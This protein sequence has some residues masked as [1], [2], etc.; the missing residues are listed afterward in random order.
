M[1]H[2]VRLVVSALAVYGLLFAVSSQATDVSK[3]P[4]KGNLLVKPNVI[5]GM[6][7]SGSMDTEVMLYTNDG[8]F[9]WDFNARSGWGIDAN[10]PSSALRDK[11]ALWFNVDGNAVPR[12]RKMVYL[13][14]NGS[15]TGNRKMLDAEYDHFAVMPT[16]QF[17]FLRSSSY[18]SI[19]YDPMVTYDPW[20]PAHLSTGPVTP[21]NADATAARSHPM[22]GSTTMNLTT[23]VTRPATGVAPAANTVF[24]ALPGMRVPAGASKLVCNAT[25]GGCAANWVDVAA[26]EDASTTGVTRVAMNYYPATY[27]VKESCTVPSTVS[28]ATDSC[29]TAPDGATLKRYEIKSGNTFPSGRS[30]ADEMQNFANWFQY[31]RKR[32]LML[33]AA[34]GETMETLS[35]MRVGVVAF[36]AR[37]NVTMYDTDATSTAAN[38]RR[39]AG[40]F[41]EVNRS[42][43]TPTRETLNYIGKQFARTG[44]VQYACQRNSA[45]IVT[46]G[47]ANA[48]TLNVGNNADNIPAYDAGRSATSFGATGAPYQDIYASSLADIATRYYVNRL[49]GNAFEAGA[50]SPT[51]RDPNTDQHINTY[52]LTMGARGTIFL[53]DKSEPP[54]STTAWP[55]PTAMRSPT[56][57][58]DLWHATI[59][60]RGR[61]YLATTPQETA[62]KI[63]EGLL[64]I[65]NQVGSQS[66][67]AVSSVNLRRG[68]SKAYLGTYNPQGWGGDVT[69]NQIDKGTGVVAK[70]ALWSAAARLAA[71]DWT[72]RVI[73]TYNGSAAVDF[74]A[75]NVGSVINPTGAWGDNSAL[76]DY[77]RGKRT[78]EGTTYRKRTSLIGAIIN[79]RPAV[80]AEDNVIYAASSSGMVH[81]I[82]AT[83][84]E[85][86]WSYVPRSVLPSIGETSDRAWTF[87][88][89]LDGSPT[90]ARIGTKKLLVGGRGAA[91]SGY[92]A[93]DVTT[94][95]AM[96]SPGAFSGKVWEFESSSTA[97]LGLSMGRPVVVDT[98]DYG[99]VVLVT[100]GYNS[101]ANDGKSRLFVLDAATGTVRDTL[102]ADSGF[103]TG[104]PGL[105][106]VSAMSEGTGKVIYVYGGDERGNLWRFNLDDQ[107]V[108]RIATLKDTAGATQ[109]V[110][111]APE[112]ALIEGQRVVLVGTGRLLGLSDFG[113]SQVQS[114]YAIKDAASP[115]SNVRTELVARVLGAESEKNLRS[116]SGDEF[117]WVTNRGWYFDLPS[118]QQANTDP[119]V[120]FGAVA[121][122]T[123]SASISN[124][125]TSSYLYVV[126]LLTG[127]N[128][129]NSEY[130]AI[131][132]NDFLGSSVVILTTDGSQPDIKTVGNITTSNNE[133]VT[134]KLDLNPGVVPRKNSWRQVRRE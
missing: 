36:N 125:K 122:T 65:L 121:F 38:G 80:S 49:G 72:Q 23:N 20:A 96:T 120:A 105:A 70:T 3:R 39:V 91:G 48:S 90:L 67:V 100:S 58:D 15:G 42:G 133:V 118:G 29:T 82:D 11:T 46:D 74:T 115:V 97:P 45:F 52:G 44:I 19:Y 56:S 104:D 27:W 61:M 53:G 30:Y 31:F 22:Y 114:F 69:A 2:S 113:S 62:L 128:V 106:Q 83:N 1:K 57:V 4:I 111:T 101:P 9:W 24:T 73:V 66:S 26:D 55:A 63:Q 50:V 64:D 81:A 93:I 79:A 32:Q 21:G 60:G 123:N 43:G 13:F 33:A 78:G 127:L 34:M 110:T 109:P 98:A 84:G 126:D 87:E 51:E 112:L 102:V 35:G 37:S 68:D 75:G 14:P 12:W 132:V 47:F 54:T 119:T 18:N 77:L 107:T 117:N 40:V 71:R 6:D 108:T 134:E 86:L 7:D 28:V 41:Y 99:P 16:T 95:R 103:A 59:N 17:A 85:E 124:C 8:A 92:Y 131:K 94:P 25:N 116:L 130:A 88:T 129:K 5:F 76:V 10:H 89:L